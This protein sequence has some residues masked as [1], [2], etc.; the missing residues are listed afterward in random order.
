M[1]FNLTLARPDSTETLVH[2]IAFINKRRFKTGLISI[3]TAAWDKTNQRIKTGTS[4][5]L[6]ALQSDLDNAITAIVNLHNQL[7]VNDGVELSVEAM[8]DGVKR[9][10]EGKVGVAEKVLSFN[11]WVDEFIEETERGERTNQMGRQIDGRTVQKY[12]TTQK[13]LDAFSKRV[14]GRVIRF[15]EIDEKFVGQWA[16][17]RSEGHGTV[18]GVGI[19]TIAK[20]MAVIKTWMKTSFQREVHNNRKWE[21]DAFKPREVKVAKPHLTM[22]EVSQLETFKIPKKVHNNGVERTSWD[23]VRD[24][25]IIA[26]W[27]AARVSDLKQFRD[28]I[29]LRYKENGNSCPDQL[30]FIQSKTNSEVTVPMLEPVKRIVNRYKG[31]LPKLPNESKMNSTVKLVC[32]AAGL[33]R[34]IE[35]ASTDAK[36]KKISRNELWELVTNHTARRTFATNVYNLDI[37]SLG[38]L[39]SLTGHE[40]ESSLMVYLNVSRSDVSK[41]AGL[42]LTAKAKELGL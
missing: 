29:D 8:R 36:S 30:T 17:F 11:Q 37:M 1:K 6:I 39:M 2:L 9:M 27:T 16:K 18:A 24:W 21:S 26:C 32:K 3:P 4:K 13:M 10:K 33:D 35:Q 23:S 28:L 42:R 38:E 5:N 40:S 41:R 15:D 12:R 22:E 7:V 14:W 25:F 31:Q 20:D 19:N 34:V